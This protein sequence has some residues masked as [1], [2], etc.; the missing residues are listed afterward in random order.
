MLRSDRVGRPAPRHRR[1]A[2]GDGHVGGT[3]AIQAVETRDR[4]RFGIP[5]RAGGD[6]KPRP[7]ERKT[8]GVS[9]GSGVAQVRPRWVLSSV[10]A[11]SSGLRRLVVRVLA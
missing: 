3:N 7:A 1:A 9:R 11:R 6:R 10:A 8:D 5:A 4:P 2:I